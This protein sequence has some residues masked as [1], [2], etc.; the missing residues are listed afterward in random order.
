MKR[1]EW[2]QDQK[3]ETETQGETQK[4]NRREQK[5]K[6]EKE[7]NPISNWEKTRRERQKA[8]Q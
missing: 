8:V 2:N 5:R 1:I 7:E 4:E 3:A 6:E